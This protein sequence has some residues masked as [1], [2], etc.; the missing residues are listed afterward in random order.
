MVVIHYGYCFIISRPRTGAQ[1]REEKSSGSGGVCS[2]KVYENN[3]L[4]SRIRKTF[5]QDIV[6]KREQRE[7][8]KK[9]SC[10]KFLRP[11]KQGFSLV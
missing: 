8:L 1:G 5:Y 3:F 7:G 2:E 4:V 11:C 9:L 6:V 10:E